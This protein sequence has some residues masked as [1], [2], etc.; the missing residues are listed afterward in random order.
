LAAIRHASVAITR[1]R[2][3]PRRR[4]LSAQILSASVVRF[5]AASDRRPEASA[6]SPRR[7]MRE[8]ASMTRKPRR[9]GL[10]TSSRQL[11]VPR[12]RAA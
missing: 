6:P 8:K 7:M 5:M 2:D 3:T 11:L 1:D 10:A 12:S 9:D 4:I